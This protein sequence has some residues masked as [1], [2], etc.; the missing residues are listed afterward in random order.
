MMRD[1]RLEAT[2]K[3]N[4][5]DKS[6]ADKGVGGSDPAGGD[7]YDELLPAAIDVGLEGGA[8]QCANCPPQADSECAH[9]AAAY[10]AGKGKAFFDGL[11]T[12]C[13]RWGRPACPCSS[14]G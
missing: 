13:W 1:S 9:E 4:A 11:S 5:E 8:E 3:A 10:P 2:A 12:W 6:K 14:A 7:D